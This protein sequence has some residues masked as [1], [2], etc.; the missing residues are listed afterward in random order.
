MYELAIFDRDQQEVQGM[1]WLISKYTFPIQAIHTETEIPQLIKLLEN[2]AVQII[3][4]EL[5]MI[6]EAK[7]EIIK[8]YLL[9]FK[10]KIITVTAEATFERASQAMSINAVDLWVKP[11]SPNRMK[12]T[13]QK[14]IRQL[15]QSTQFL[16]KETHQEIGYHKLFRDDYQPFLYPVYLIKPQH[17]AD[18]EL[19]QQFIKQFDFYD[20]PNIFSRSDGIV[21][22]FQVDLDH[23]FEQAQRFLSEWEQEMNRPLSIVVHEGAPDKS[24]N[25]I[26]QQVLKAMELTFFRGYRQV[27][28]TEMA[29]KWVDIDPFLTVEEQ[30]NWIKMLDD[31]LSEA[32]KAWMYEDFF[33]LTS[34]Y[35]EPGLLRT[36]LTSILAQVRRFMKQKGINECEEDYQNIFHLILYESVLYRIVQDFILFIHDLF[37]IMDESHG[38]YDVMEAALR[39]MEENYAR[40]D[41]S[42]IEVAEF[43]SRSPSYFSSLISKKLEQSFRQLLIQIRIEKAKEKLNTTDK[44]IQEIAEEVGFNQ[45]NYFS[46]VFKTVTGFSPLE[47]RQGS[48]IQLAKSK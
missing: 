20:P 15:E 26:Y 31:K 12:Q 44:Q 5:D 24:L 14:V 23:A 32:I 13:L 45:A 42:L 25:Q 28:S 8:S 38:K 36:R 40:A 48:K 30:R 34:P 7:W 33:K 29:G 21:I 37:E 2:D 11:I 9:S 16:Q 39:Y 3:C 19:L 1:Q 46:K 43:V 35:P 41:L 22:V 4:L 17:K 6:P 47:W 18:L 27:I 10:G